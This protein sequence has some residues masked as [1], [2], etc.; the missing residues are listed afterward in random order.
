MMFLNWA[1]VPIFWLITFI[2]EEQGI[3]VNN[4][5]VSI[6]S[7]LGDLNNVS[8]SAPALGQLLAWSGTQWQPTAPAAAN[9]SSSSIGEL[10]NVDITGVQSATVL[11]ME[12]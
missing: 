9:L 8:S 4:L 3:N 12:W 1:I 11:G 5:V 7:N 2:P 6:D 10:N